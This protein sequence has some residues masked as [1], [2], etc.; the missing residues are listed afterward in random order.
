MLERLSVAPS[1]PRG[2]MPAVVAAFETIGM[3]KTA[4][5]AFEA[6][7]LGFLRPNDHI[8]F[9]RE[10][11]LSDAKNRALELTQNYRPP[12]PVKLILPGP[13]GKAALLLMVKELRAQGKLAA[14][15]ELIATLLAEVLSGGSTADSSAP[16]SEEQILRLERE[17]VLRLLRTEATAARMEHMLNTGRP[18]RN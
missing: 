3:A 16:V 18:L 4:K 2:P 10:R 17:A 13:S 7:E 9:N 12:E 8:T 6:K 11:L 1:L 14:H 5:S 15:D